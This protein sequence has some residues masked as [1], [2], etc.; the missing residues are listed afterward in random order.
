MAEL[1]VGL[2]VG[3][4]LF[5]FLS[6]SLFPFLLLF[7]FLFFP[8]SMR[9]SSTPVH[10]LPLSSV[11]TATLYRSSPSTVFRHRD[12]DS[13]ADRADRRHGGHA[14]ILRPR[15][16]K[17]HRNRWN[18]RLENLTVSR[19]FPNARRISRGEIMRQGG[20]DVFKA[21]K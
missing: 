13:F 8:P 11:I 12:R 2:S 9:F 10:P 17:L 3:G 1:F 15:D 5:S 19:Y 6:S 21:D 18:D 7:P 4:S 20:D 16:E 14:A